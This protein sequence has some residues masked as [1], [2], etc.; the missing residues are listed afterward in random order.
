MGQELNADFRQIGSL[1]EQARAI[2]QFHFLIAIPL[3][4]VNAAI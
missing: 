1:R 2:R 4:I 3:F